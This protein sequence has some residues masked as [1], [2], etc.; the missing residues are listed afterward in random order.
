MS[1]AYIAS[2]TAFLVAGIH[3]EGIIYWILPTIIGTFFIVY[4]SIKAKKGKI[5]NVI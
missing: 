2:I 3:L 4:W 1:G 5:G